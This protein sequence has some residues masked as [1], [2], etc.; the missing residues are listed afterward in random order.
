MKMVA[1]RRRLTSL[2]IALT[3]KASTPLTVEV[4]L[5]AQEILKCA[6]Q[7]I[8]TEPYSQTINCTSSKNFQNKELSQNIH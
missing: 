6:P 3:V 2:R 1:A 7:L 8:A 4:A 5:M